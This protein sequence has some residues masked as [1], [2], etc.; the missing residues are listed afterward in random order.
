VLLGAC[1]LSTSVERSEELRVH[2]EGEAPGAVEV[3]TSREF[4]LAETEDGGEELSF[5]TSDTASVLLPYDRTFPLAPTYQFAVRVQAPV[6]DSVLV[7]MAVFADGTE[8]FRRTD[9][10]LDRPLDF[11][12]SSN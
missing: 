10:L 2:V 6:E 3:I 5:L 1:Q 11:F 7:T 9:H 4:I 12:F 8:R